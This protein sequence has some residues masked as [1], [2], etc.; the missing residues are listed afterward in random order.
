MYNTLLKLL[1]AMCRFVAL[2]AAIAVLIWFPYN[3]IAPVEAHL[4]YATVFYGLWL[5]VIGRTLVLKGLEV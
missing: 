3:Q 5:V 4:S 2:T 1:E